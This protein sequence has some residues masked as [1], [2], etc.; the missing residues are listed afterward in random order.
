M[1]YSDDP[2][3]DFERYDA[4]KEEELR[5][6]PVC[7]ECGEYIQ[8]SDAVRINGNWYCDGCLED[9]REEIEE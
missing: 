7:C 3:A 1:F 9:M 2:V 5:K 4:E 8:Q 6:L